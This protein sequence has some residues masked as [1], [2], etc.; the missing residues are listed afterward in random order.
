MTY[1]ALDFRGQPAVR[2][3]PAGGGSVT[4][5]LHGGQVLSWIGADGIERLYLSPSAKFDGKT[6][7]RGGVPVCWPQ[8]NQR[9]P[10]PKHGFA[11]NA[12]WQAEP[13]DPARPDTVALVLADSDATRALWPHAFRARLAVT[14]APKALHIE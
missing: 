3:A 11:R 6:A 13:A 14:L 4:V 10:L 12:P 8:F 7:I 9:G 5:A 2:L 1:Q